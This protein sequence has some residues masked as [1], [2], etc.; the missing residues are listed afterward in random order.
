MHLEV[1]MNMRMKVGFLLVVLLGLLL[2]A[3]GGGG[4]AQVQGQPVA[5]YYQANC[6]TCHG[7]ERQG[8]VAPPLLPSELDQPDSA[9]VDIIKNGQG[10]MPAWGDQ[11]TDEEIN[12]LVE[13]I[14][15][16]P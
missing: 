15:T 13:F 4:G 6:A 14:Q 5:D 9:Y 11:L 2:A 1:D 8:D 7:T 12:H 10:G 3:C 16:E